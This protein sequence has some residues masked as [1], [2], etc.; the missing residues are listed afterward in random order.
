MTEP[1]HRLAAYELEDLH[2]HRQT[3]LTD[4]ARRVMTRLGVPPELRGIRESG[5]LAIH[6]T[7]EPFTFETAQG[8]RN[9]KP[10]RQGQLEALGRLRVERRGIL[11]D[12]GILDDGLLDLESWRTATIEIRMEAVIAHEFSEYQSPGRHFSWRHADALLR[13]R[14]NPHLSPQA[15]EILEDLV[16]RAADG[17]DPQIAPSLAERIRR[18][19]TKGIGIEDRP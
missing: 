12:G 14:G 18:V 2:G 1:S 13:S 19:L 8:G 15:R 3:E 17:N 4:L 16:R 5:P 10:G 7:G 6:R 11:V 9:T